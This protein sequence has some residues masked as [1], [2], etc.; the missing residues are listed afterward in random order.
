[1]I[2]S[3]KFYDSQ[4]GSA[5]WT[6]W[7]III[8][9]YKFLTLCTL[10][11]FYHLSFKKSERAYS[12]SFSLSSSLF[13]AMWPWESSLHLSVYYF[14]FSLYLFLS[15]SRRLPL[16]LTLYLFLSLYS[17]RLSPSLSFLSLAITSLFWAVVVGGRVRALA[18]LVRSA[19]WRR[20]PERRRKAAG[21]ILT[22]SILFYYSLLSYA[23]IA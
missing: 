17:L 6:C 2:T 14:T 20:Q 22:L 15:L 4:K 9:F 10:F 8:A 13:L 11:K 19:E 12:F 5:P 3:T 1:M 16:S 7:I 23:Q 21:L 18:L